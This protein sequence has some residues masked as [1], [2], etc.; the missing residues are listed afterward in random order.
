MCLAA[1][2]QFA[3]LPRVSAC[4]RKSSR[5]RAKRRV[6]EVTEWRDLVGEKTGFVEAVCQNYEVLVDDK[7]V[8]KAED[9]GSSGRYDTRSRP[10][11]NDAAPADSQEREKGKISSFRLSS[12]IEKT[13]DLRK[14]S[15]E[16]ILDSRVELTLGIAKKEFHGDIIDLVK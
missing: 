3:C 8:G 7:R 1:P 13:M 6:R 4:G 12:K 15:E 9:A 16:R 14:V 10:K 11:R 2:R 5:H